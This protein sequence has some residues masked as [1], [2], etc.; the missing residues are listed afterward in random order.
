MAAPLATQLALKHLRLIAAIAEHRQLS[1][2]ADALA[3]TQPAASRTL[4]EAEARIGAPL[5]DRH[6]KG[7]TLTDIGE[8][9]ARRARNILDELNDAS[10][11][12][13]RLRLGRGG[14]VRIGAV[15]GAAVGYVAPA[16]RQLKALAPDVELHIDVATSD[17][18]MDGLLALRH[19]MVLGRVP[20][21]AAVEDLALHRAKGEQ[22]RI[23]AHSAHPFVHREGIALTDLG[24]QDWVMQGPGAPIRRAVEEVFLAQGAAL[25]RNVTNTSSLVMVLAMLQNP[26][27]VTPVS[28]EVANLLTRG[29]RDLA[30][31]PVT[32]PIHVAPYS[33][34]TLRDR[35]L[36]PAASR[37]HNLLAKLIA[38]P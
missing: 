1:I 37:C 32:E 12:V 26:D 22:V 16:I 10:A 11:E 8:S 27:V 7:M 2:A 25:P 6:P 13:D 9:L 3:M 36:S 31:L 14:V 19:D 17:A 23:L 34:I 4:G 33:L 18:L 24:D 20:A 38:P 15:T 30:Q 21:G 35:R 5:F 28:Q 29:N